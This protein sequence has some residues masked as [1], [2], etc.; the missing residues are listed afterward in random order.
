[1]KS[2]GGAWPPWPTWFLR[3]CAS[4]LF[5]AN[6]FSLYVN[7][8]FSA[9][10]T[11]RTHALRKHITLP[12]KSVPPIIIISIVTYVQIESMHVHC[13]M[14]LPRANTTLFKCSFY[15]ISAPK[16]KP[17][18]NGLFQTHYIHIS[19]KEK[20]VC[21]PSSEQT[22]ILFVQPLMLHLYPYSF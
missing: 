2:G 6:F 15:L 18:E 1:M 13:N 19:Y 3:L 17:I 14:S 7:Y 21:R 9:S 12:V 16:K 22:S 10:I 20:N 8:V 11:S 5:N 4:F